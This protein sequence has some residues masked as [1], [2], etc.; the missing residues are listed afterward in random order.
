MLDKIEIQLKGTGI[1]TS[2][3]LEKLEDALRDFLSGQGYNGEIED[4]ITG[5]TTVFRAK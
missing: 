1:I 5:N 2:E 4:H 3:E